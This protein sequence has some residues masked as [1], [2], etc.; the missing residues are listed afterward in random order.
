MEQLQTVPFTPGAPIVVPTKAFTRDVQES[1]IDN[2]FN[3][4]GSVYANTVDALNAQRDKVLQEQQASL[5][6]K[7]EQYEA[8]KNLQAMID[9]DPNLL[10]DIANLRLAKQNQVPQA[11]PQAPSLNTGVP[12]TEGKS[13][14]FDIMSLFSNDSSPA[15]NQQQQHD[16][17]QPAPQEQ[18]PVQNQQPN[19]DAALYAECIK[20]GLD[21]N[22][23]STFTK[24]I[25]SDP[26]A[27]VELY[28][29][30]K[31]V[32]SQQNAPTQPVVQ[33]RQ[34]QVQQQQVQI[35]SA[36]VNLSEL[37]TPSYVS[38]LAPAAIGQQQQNSFWR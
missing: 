33:Q 35:E 28:S 19:T 26:S 14:T 38:V 9:S 4:T 13:E 16:Q 3:S 31:Q 29:A 17:Q 2:Y 15:T 32:E 5:Q 37:P 6:M 34:Q 21:Y 20:S 36:P 22:A 10:T 27:L 12:N 24:S 11:Q 7:P 30:Y 1:I 8:L 25:I 23:V 18:A